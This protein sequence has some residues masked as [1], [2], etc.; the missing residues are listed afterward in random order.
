[1]AEVP[2]VE[3]TA[4]AI[5]DDAAPI[6]LRDQPGP[7]I[8]LVLRGR[9]AT[10]VADPLYTAALVALERGCSVVVDCEDATHVGGASLQIL[11]ALRKSLAERGLTLGLRG[12]SAGVR[13]TLTRLGVADLDAAGAS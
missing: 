12:V 10:Q 11:L 2:P 5:A 9:V 1:V 7:I 6:A 8:E 3:P 13:D 4:A